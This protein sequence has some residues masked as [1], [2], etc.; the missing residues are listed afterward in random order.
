MQSGEEITLK[1]LSAALKII[2]GSDYKVAINLPEKGDEDLRWFTRT[3]APKGWIEQT[4]EKQHEYSRRYQ[5]I[6]NEGL[7]LSPA[8][9]QPFYTETPTE[10]DD[11]PPA[12]TKRRKRSRRSQQVG[13]SFRNFAYE[14]QQVV[15][16]Y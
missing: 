3:S 2:K 16:I 14:G 15:S 11:D 1:V 10:M 8:Q 6:F 7:S 4:R 12:D 13:Y 5:E 9:L